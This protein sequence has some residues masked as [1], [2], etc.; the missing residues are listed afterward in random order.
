VSA[1]Y[2]ELIDLT[3]HHLLTA[4]STT[5]ETKIASTTKIMTALLVIQSGQLNR[6]V[7]IKQ[8]YIDYVIANDASNA[9]L[10]VGDRLTV[11]QLLYAMMLP[12][13]CDA[14]YALAD[15]LGNGH[16]SGV[17]NFVAEMNQE[18]KQLGLTHTYYVNADG[19]DNPDSHGHYAYST[20][21]DL[22][23]LT[24]YALS[25]P[26]FR[27]VVGTATYSLPATATHQAYTW[28]NTNHLLTTYQGAIGVKTGTTPQ[29]GYC[30]VFAA[31]RNGHTLLG[32]VLDSTSNDQRYQD[33][34]ALLN[35]GFSIV[36]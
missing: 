9:G 18:A 27:Q 2:A 12:S 19:L 10:V 7:L 6:Q 13:G 11:S 16:T 25:N 31:T 23:K 30:L 8:S 3:T 5:T 28:T 1:P 15:V 4:K 32:V 22:V 35:W 24:S 34:T 29:A 20:A 36:A 14:A 33:T 26:L 17:A 21:A